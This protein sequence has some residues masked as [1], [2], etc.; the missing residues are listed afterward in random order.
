MLVRE[1]SAA[2]WPGIWAIVEPTIRAGDT[3][4]WD[5][6]TDEATAR[7]IWM[8]MPPGRT[9]VAVDGEGEGTVV[10]TAE[11]HPNQG[12]PGSH[13]VNGGYMVHPDHRGRGVGRALGEH[14]VAVAAGDGYRGM[15]YNAVAATNTAS[16]QLW[17][18][19]GFE[20]IATVPD[21]FRHPTEGFVGLHVMYRP[22]P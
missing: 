7:S 19:L 18:T 10:G 13:I 21:G 3:F 6:E 17:R 14:V 20:I 16:I 1:A 11:I 2:D 15:Q 12:G 5:P 8:K 22:L 9:F 4:T